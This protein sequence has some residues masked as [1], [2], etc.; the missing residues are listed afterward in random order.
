MRWQMGRRSTNVEDR[1][2]MSVPRAGGV[3]CLGLVVIIVIAYLTGSN[4]LELLQ[5]V[6]TDTSVSNQAPTV[7]P[8][9]N[10][11]EGEFVRTVLGKYRRR[12]DASFLRRRSAISGSN[13]RAF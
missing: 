11:E 6:G 3:G 10:D 9:A 13:T 4:P 8:G 7:A 5:Q 12:M 1:R 2:G